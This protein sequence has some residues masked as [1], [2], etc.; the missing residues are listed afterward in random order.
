MRNEFRITVIFKLDE[1]GK[2][3]FEQ[4]REPFTAVFIRNQIFIRVYLWLGFATCSRH[5]AYNAS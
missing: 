4:I 2:K 5:Q 1:P 3:G